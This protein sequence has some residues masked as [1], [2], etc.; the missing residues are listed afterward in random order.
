LD[1]ANDALDAPTAETK[2]QKDEIEEGNNEGSNDDGGCTNEE[3]FK[4]RVSQIGTQVKW[5]E[6][7]R[8][9]V[10]KEK[11]GEEYTDATNPSSMT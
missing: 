3:D 11:K 1:R 2:V 6:R 7:F 10:V 8:C 5:L 9:E 4:P